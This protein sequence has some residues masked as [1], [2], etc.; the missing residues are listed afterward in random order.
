MKMIDAAPRLAVLVDT[1]EEFDWFQPFS[2]DNRATTHMAELWRFQEI[3]VRHQ[4]VPT[5]MCDHPVVSD[6]AAVALLSEWRDAGTAR[7]GAHLHPWVNPPHDEVV[8]YFNSFSGNLDVELERRKLINLCAAHEAAFGQRPTVYMAGRYGIGPDS[9]DTL[10][11]L[12]FLVDVSA[13]PPIDYS[14]EGGPDFTGMDCAPFWPR[15]KGGLYCLPI[16]G[17]RVGWLGQRKLGRALDR[18]AR[19]PAGEAA[20]APGLLARLGISDRLR[21][22][23]EGYRLQDMQRLTKALWA[24]GQRVFA[25]NLHSPSAAPGHTPYART[26]AERDA[27]LARLDAYLAWF[28]GEFGGVATEPLAERERALSGADPERRGVLIPVRWSAAVRKTAPRLGF[29]SLRYPPENAIAALRTGKMARRLRARGFDL[30]V[31]T[32]EKTTGDRSLGR[33]TPESCEISTDFYDLDAAINPVGL[34]RRWWGQSPATA[35]H[36]P[37]PALAPA[38]RSGGLRAALWRL[39]SDVYNHLALFP[40]RHVGWQRHL[41]PALDHWCQVRKPDLLYVSAPPFSQIAAVSRVARKHRLPLVVEFRDLWADEA[42]PAVPRWRQ[43]LDAWGERRAMRGASAIVTVSEPWAA[44]YRAK[45]G[46]PTLS[47]M[48]G[49]DPVDFNFSASPPRGGPLRIVYAGSIYLGRRDPTPLFRALVEG[50]FTPEQV[51]VEFI[52]SQT[53]YIRSAMIETGAAPFVILSPPVGYAEALRRQKAADVLLLLQWADPRNNGNV[54]AKVFEQLA[55][56]RPV[57]GIGPYDGV[58][59]KL[60]AE[61]RAGHFANTPAELIPLLREWVAQ[62]QGPNGQ[63]TP[64]PADAARG[65]ERDAQFDLLVPFL[66]GLLRP[67]PPERG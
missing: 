6:P 53:D 10:T 58:P 37:A 22:T 66:K 48:N 11:E 62:K 59:A 46:L 23:P 13:A 42:F 57:L 38:A 3:F 1:E 7:I 31:F 35:S 50:G 47:V 45:Y 43:W 30:T 40:D 65:L 33:E 51:T 15:R 20:H 12:G 28:R 67:P 27:L 9:F 24:R 8:S 34:M 16:S 61:R 21:L 39:A 56:G 19:S 26:L 18:F 4:M 55:L 29:V 14:R 64:P 25:L 44:L 52:S 60:I 36:N 54:P 17:A 49:F 41:V 32:T 5:Y 2:R 63:V